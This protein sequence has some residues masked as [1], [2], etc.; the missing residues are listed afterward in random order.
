MLV[1]IAVLMSC[2]IFLAV[3]ETALTRM[4]RTKAI[5]LVDGG[6]RRSRTLLRLVESTDRWLNPLLLVILAMQLVQAT[7]IGVV[8]ERLLGRSA[9]PWPPSSTS[10]SSSSWAEAAPKTWALQHPER[11]ALLAPAPSPPSPPSR[12]CGCSRAA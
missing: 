1:A 2:S 12:P 5:S 11:A 8:S 7:L 10:P 9:S 3:A 4:T 6:Q